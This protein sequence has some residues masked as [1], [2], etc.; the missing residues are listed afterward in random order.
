MMREMT[1]ISG[2]N[3]AFLQSGERTPREMVEFLKEGALFRS[4][5][6]VLKKVYPG[7]D[8]AQRLAKGLEEV[9]GED[10]SSISRKVRNWM[11]GQ[12]L[13]K[14]RET[15]FQ[16][17]FVLNLNE[18]EAN[19]VMGSASEMGIHY[20]NPGELAYAFCLRTGRSY[21]EAVELRKKALELYDTYKENKPEAVVYTR[22]V[23]DAF[24]QVNTEEE[25]E[26]FFKEHAGELGEL[27]ETAY[28]K[29]IE[30]LDR[31]QNPEGVNGEGER[32]YTMEEVVK[33][34]IRMKV[35]QTKKSADFSLL[36]RL[37]KK[38]WPNE[39]NLLNMRNRKEDVSRKVMILLYLIT[40]AFDEWE[41][42][43]DG[44]DGYYLDDF[45]EEDDADTRLECRF[46]KMKVFLNAYGMNQLDPGNPFDF[47]VLY[48]MK[49]QEGDFVS[50]RLEAVLDVLFED[51]DGGKKL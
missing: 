39:S 35:P 43:E 51:K 25:L 40:E 8:L 49:T 20:R 30:L 29:F 45:D 7:E 27:H 41:E 23:W 44:D 19:R 5:D 32:K 6:H 33:E 42:D 1:E 10:G 36:Q 16:I 50:D 13:P 11:K 34:Y 26:E 4:F 31:L 9:T 38:Y 18:E 15:L 37:V 21:G 24:S 17:C 46:E 48:A 28:K 2:N 47:L 22:Q 14:N 12:N 3:M